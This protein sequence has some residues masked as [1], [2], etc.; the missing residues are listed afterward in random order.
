MNAF[1]VCLETEQDAVPQS[2]K[3]AGF[4]VGERDCGATSEQRTCFAPEHDCLSRTSARAVANEAASSFI[5]VFAIGMSGEDQFGD[6]PQQV[7]ATKHLAH[8]SLKLAQL[9][10]SE[11]DPDFGFRATRRR[12]EDLRH[13]VDRWRLDVESEQE[14]IELRLRERERAL[15]FDR[16]LCCHHME[17]VRKPVRRSR[18]G[19]RVFLHRLEQSRLRLGCRAVDLVSQHEPAEEGAR[20][21][22]ESPPPSLVV[23]HL[24]SRCIARHEVG[25]E[26][27][28]REFEAQASTERPNQ[29]GLAEPWQTLEQHVA[30]GQDG[31][32][33]IVDE[34]F[35][36]DHL[37]SQLL[38][39]GIDPGHQSRRPLLHRMRHQGSSRSAPCNQ[40]SRGTSWRA[41]EGE[42]V[43]SGVCPTDPVMS[44]TMR[45]MEQA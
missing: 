12:L 28:A 19:D 35:L 33:Q 45:G 17:R 41:K 32:Q 13:R 34:C 21:K 7:R 9:F 14:P 37:P 39:Q 26:L 36:P 16:I 8:E 38:S 40:A 30:P 11:L 20:L 27:D 31:S 42:G 5:A 15:Q 10:G 4:D 6:E 18:D 43:S 2:G 44:A 29:H 25:R 24:G 3:Q 1:R 23:D 22:A